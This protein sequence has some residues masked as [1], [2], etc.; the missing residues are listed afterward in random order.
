MFASIENNR[1]VLGRYTQLW[2]KTKNQIEAISNGEP[3]EY[4]TFH[5]N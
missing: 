4:K 5:D 2:D 3:I 1:E